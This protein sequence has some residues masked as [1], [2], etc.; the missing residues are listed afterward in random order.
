MW[1]R[2]D[3]ILSPKIRTS[4][5]DLRRCAAI[6]SPYGPAPTI[7][8]SLIRL[9]SSILGRASHRLEHLVDVVGHPHVTRPRS[10]EVPGIALHV[11]Q[12][13]EQDGGAERQL[14]RAR[15]HTHQGLLVV[16]QSVARDDIS[17]D[18]TQLLVLDL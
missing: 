7:A 1:W 18:R 13:H 10:F 11:S 2:H 5:P 6:E 8:T 15:S 3:A 12:P 14:A 16:A 9:L 4:R 17:D